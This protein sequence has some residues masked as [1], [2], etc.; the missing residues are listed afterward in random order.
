LDLPYLRDGDAHVT[1]MI[2]MLEYVAKNYGGRDML[3]ASL[4]DEA[5]VDMLL[6]SVDSMMRELMRLGCPKRPA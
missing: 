3:G 5:H 6:W 1:D 2:P 4:K